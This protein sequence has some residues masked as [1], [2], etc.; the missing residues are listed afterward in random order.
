MYFQDEHSVSFKK[1]CN[2]RNNNNYNYIYL[3]II[4]F[5][6]DPMV[7]LASLFWHMHIHRCM[8]GIFVR[9][10]GTGSTKH[11]NKQMIGLLSKLSQNLDT[12]QSAGS[13]SLSNN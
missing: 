9:C 13:T 2:L 10:Y 6:L 1:K 11:K 3:C 12:N 4:I 8:C 7:K 5:I